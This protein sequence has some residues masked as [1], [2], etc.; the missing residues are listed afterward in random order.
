MF[1]IFHSIFKNK[2]F[3]PILKFFWHFGKVPIFIGGIT[4][5]VASVWEPLAALLTVEVLT[6]IAAKFAFSVTELVVVAVVADME[7]AEP[8]QEINWLGS[9]A[10]KGVDVWAN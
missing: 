2:F 9:R 8:P 4:N 1:K 3:L 7:A 10:A 5:L 6:P